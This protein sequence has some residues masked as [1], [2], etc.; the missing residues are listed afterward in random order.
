M[1][2]ILFT[3]CIMCAIL[4]ACSK[5]KKVH[6]GALSLNNQA[7]E[8]ISKGKCADALGMLN[9]AISLDSTYTTA[10]AN[11]MNLLVSLQRYGEALDV[12]DKIIELLPNDS[13]SYQ[14][15]G[16]ILEKIGAYKNA[17][18]YYKRAYELYKEKK[19]IKA[20]SCLQGF[21][22]KYLTEGID[23]SKEEIISSMPKSFTEQEKN[24]IIAFLEH[25]GSIKELHDKMI[26]DTIY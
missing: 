7:C 16:H 3:I 17:K 8:L 15:K 14:F 23:T 21:E 12:M 5:E 18:I 1:K 19:E 25:V 2:R 9:Q 10:Y 13:Y 4:V 24:Y 11:K 6:P 26:K 20:N 22:L